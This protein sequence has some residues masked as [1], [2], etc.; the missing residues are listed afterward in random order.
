MGANY[1]TD[2][3]KLTGHMFNIK[4]GKKSYKISFK[5]LPVKN[6]GQ[7]TGKRWAHYLPS[8]PPSPGADMVKKLSLS[9]FLL[10]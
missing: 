9:L 4:L 10:F 3:K 8:A 1:L 7:K 6:S 5:A 2:Q